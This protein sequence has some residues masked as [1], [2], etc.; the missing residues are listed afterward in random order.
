MSVVSVPALYARLK[1]KNVLLLNHFDK[2]EYKDINVPVS[3][4][5]ISCRLVVESAF[6]TENKGIEEIAIDCL[7]LAVD[8]SR[9]KLIELVTYQNNCFAMFQLARV[10]SLR[11]DC[12][13]R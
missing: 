3:V 11:W 4:W 9:Y 10:P 5:K 6:L 7:S 1:I 12:S 8:Q 2:Y 13:S